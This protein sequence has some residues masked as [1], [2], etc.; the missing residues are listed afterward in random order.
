MKLRYDQE[1]GSLKL[2]PKNGG[3]E[4]M[5]VA[6]LRVMTEGGMVHVETRTGR[7]LSAAIPESSLNEAPKE[8]LDL[9]SILDK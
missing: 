7:G 8:V 1:D 9:I 3:D 4:M 6:L 5:I 2:L